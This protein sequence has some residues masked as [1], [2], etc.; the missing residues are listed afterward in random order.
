M[1]LYSFIS[2][3]YSFTAILLTSINEMYICNVFTRL[4]EN[5]LQ[6]MLKKCKF[7]KPH[8]KYLCHVVGLGELYFDIDKVATVRDWAPPV[9]IKGV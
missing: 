4:Y 6:A 7:G 8:V 1:I 3:T 5:E 2:A 9:N